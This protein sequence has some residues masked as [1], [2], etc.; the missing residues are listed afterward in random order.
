MSVG[1][2]GVLD[3]AHVVHHL[4][5][6]CRSVARLWTEIAHCGFRWSLGLT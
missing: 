1:M 2:L 6:A 4:V 3:S 5:E